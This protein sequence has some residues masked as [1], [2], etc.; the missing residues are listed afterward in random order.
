MPLCNG[1]LKLIDGC[2]KL[3][4]LRGEVREGML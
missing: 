3:P 4:L 2:F 1:N